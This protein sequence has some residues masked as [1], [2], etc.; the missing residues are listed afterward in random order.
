MTGKAPNQRIGPAGG[1]G[2][3]PKAI[4]VEEVRRFR[5]VRKMRLFVPN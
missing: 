5:L 3:I 1:T 4:T 2:P